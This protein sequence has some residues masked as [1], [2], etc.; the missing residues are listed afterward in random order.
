MVKRRMIEIAVAVSIIFLF[1]S[2]YRIIKC[3]DDVIL[4]RNEYDLSVQNNIDDDSRYK[5]SAIYYASMPETATN[6]NLYYNIVRILSENLKTC[7]LL[8]L[9]LFLILTI[10]CKI[11]K[12]IIEKNIVL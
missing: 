10:I 2:T 7:L 3:Y 11:K 8:S 9:I 6:V 12:E 1:L 4:A 5:E